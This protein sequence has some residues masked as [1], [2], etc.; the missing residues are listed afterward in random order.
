MPNNDAAD[1]A[2]PRHGPDSRC[3]LIKHILLHPAKKHYDRPKA[4]RICSDS[5]G[6]IDKGAQLCGTGLNPKVSINPA[7]R[8]RPRPFVRRLARRHLVCGLVVRPW[9]VT[10]SSANPWKRYV[11]LCLAPPRNHVYVSGIGI[12]LSPLA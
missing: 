8:R 5:L 9:R 2:S 11:A 1:A 6:A 7:P 3:W 4:R 12:L 10:V